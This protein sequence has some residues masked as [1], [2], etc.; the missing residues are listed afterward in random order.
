MRIYHSAN[1]RA[2][3]LIE[4]LVVIAII[5]ILASM[6]LPA[7]ARA[8]AKAAD[9]RCVNNLKQIGLA[10]FMYVNDNGSTMPYSLGNDLWMRS[11]IENY[12]KVDEIRLC[13]VAPYNKK[14]PYGSATAAWVWA[15]TV[16]DPVT[17]EPRWT[18][19]YALNG[20][21]YQGDW[22]VQDN[23]PAT[24]NAFRNESDIQNPAQTPVFCDGMWVDAWPKETD[25]PARDL[26]EGATT[27]G[28]IS[29]ITIARHGGGPKSGYKN[30][31]P[32]AR[33]PAAI[34]MVFSDGHASVTP[35]EQLW[36]L[37]WHKNWKTPATRPK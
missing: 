14:H 23:R 3:T 24:A 6:L 30:M 35:L 17:R 11:L 21:M 27:L 34:N 12:A 33:L 10:H 26:L 9:I 8:K 2:F 4:L 18:G 13:P 25:Q 37:S 5:A 31:P 7:L 29:V 15:G 22:T 1:R 36:S 32:G 28:S 16:V 20:W 19:G